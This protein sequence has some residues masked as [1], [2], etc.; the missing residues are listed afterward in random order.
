MLSLNKR[1]K[2]IS[3]EGGEGAGKTTQALL[4]QKHLEF[5]GIESILTREIGGTVEAEKIR[6]LVFSE[7]LYDTSELLMIMAARYE[8]VNKVILPA[9][10]SGV[11]VICDR[12]I[13]S[14]IS[15]Q[16]GKDLS[17]DLILSLH[18]QMI[19]PS[20]EICN[21]FQIE[22][23]LFTESGV[24]PDLTIFLDIPPEIGVGRAK[25]RGNTNKFEEESTLFHEKIYQTFQS[26]TAAYPERIKKVAVHNKSIDEIF[27]EIKA[28]I[29]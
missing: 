24:M 7:S 1:G 13:D 23:S 9:I 20:D 28:L 8:H 10:L 14:S 25:S 3:F 27:T 4:L 16:S 5:C 26:L 6:N 22:K 15:Y 29:Q 11:W 12:Y 21:K 19:V 18:R 2:F 17:L